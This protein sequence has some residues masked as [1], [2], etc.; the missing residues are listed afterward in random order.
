MTTTGPSGR[1]A[2]RYS[3]LLLAG[4]MMAVSLSAL[5][6]ALQI[7]R[8]HASSSSSPPRTDQD[9]VPS[10]SSVCGP[11]FMPAQ[12]SVSFDHHSI[13]SLLPDVF[14]YLPAGKVFFPRQN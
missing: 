7:G 3:R 1:G 10:S 5:L 12:Q 8:Y 14:H 9:D 13:T 2:A 4:L 6:F 11:P